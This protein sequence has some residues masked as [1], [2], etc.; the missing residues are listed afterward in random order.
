MNPY[1]MSPEDFAMYEKSHHGHYMQAFD[2]MAT[3]FEESQH[4]AQLALRQ[5]K[6]SKTP[7]ESFHNYVAIV[8][9]PFTGKIVLRSSSTMKNWRHDILGGEATSK[10]RAYTQSL[11]TANHSH[12]EDFDSEPAMFTPEPELHE[13]ARE[14]SDRPRQKRKRNDDVNVQ[15]SSELSHKEASSWKQGDDPDDDDCRY[16]TYRADATGDWEKWFSDAFRALQQVSCRVIAKE[17]IK[18]IHPKKQSTHP[19][20]GKNPRTRE[21]GDPNLTKP[22]YWPKDVIHKEPDHINK[23]ARTKLLV[24]LLMHTPHKEMSSSGELRSVREITAEVLQESLKQKKLERDMSELGKKFPIIEQIIDVRK[25]L[26]Q[27]E[28]GGIDGNTMI[29][30]PN[31]SDFNRGS[32][33][34]EAD[35]EADEPH[36]GDD[37]DQD[38]ANEGFEDVAGELQREMQASTNNGTNQSKQQDM[39]NDKG[40]KSKR[41]GRRRS[42]HDELRSAVGPS[43]RR[44]PYAQV[45]TS[46]HPMLNIHP[47]LILPDWDS[48]PTM[49]TMGRAPHYIQHNLSPHDMHDG[50]DLVNWATPMQSGLNLNSQSVDQHMITPP[51]MSN[52]MTPASY[53]DVGSGHSSQQSFTGAPHATQFNRSGQY[54]VDMHNPRHPSL[55]APTPYEAFMEQVSQNREIFQQRP[56]YM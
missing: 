44:E 53:V 7:I 26:E 4:R 1:G 11:H 20:N 38:G 23:E 31:F 45:S 33:N 25:S 50:F 48:R 9:D 19:Y 46:Q 12:V 32:K 21:M 29:T 15:E 17:W 39:P 42:R 18:T 52:V 3:S 22:P 24:H 51:P 6:K 37:D 55:R 16:V 35:D 49:P 5:S 13:K 27:F 40:S 28:D 43:V 30:A 36:K 2:P 14:S 34:D 47:P 54:Q 8:Q 10:F 56:Y 41:S